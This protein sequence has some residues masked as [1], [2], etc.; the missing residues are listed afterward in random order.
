[1]WSA[2]LPDVYAG[3]KCRYRVA[4]LLNGIG[5]DLSANEEKIVPEAIGLGY[6]KDVD[7]N[8]DLSANDALS[9]FA[10][11]SVDYVFDAH[12]LGN[13]KATKGVL[14]E[15]WRVVKPGGYLVLYEQDKDYYPHVGTPGAGEFR[16]KD[17]FL[18]DV[19]EIL[20]DQGAEVVSQSRHNDSNEYS[21]QLVLRK[22]HGFVRPKE[23]IQEKRKY[24]EMCFPRKK[25]TD[26]E[27]LVVRYGAL[28]DTCWITPVFSEL[29]KEGYHVVFSCTD[30]NA[31]VVRENPNIDEFHIIHKASDIPYAELNSM[32]EEIGC[33]FEKVINLTQT[34]EGELVKCEGS[35]EYNWPHEKRHKICNVNYQDRTMA[36]AGYPDNKG[37]LP[38]L[39]FTSYEEEAG[40]VWAEERKDKFVILWGLAGSAFHKVYPWAEY[41][42]SELCVNYKDIEIVTVGDD[43][44]RILEWNQPRT[45]NKCGL[46][47]VRQ[48]F[49]LTKYADLVIGPDTGLLNA[50]SA[51]STPKIV[52]MSAGSKE[53]LTK[54][55]ENTDTLFAEDCEC[56]PCHKLVYSNSCPKGTIQGIAPKC[57]ENLKPEDVMKAIIKRYSEWK[58]SQVERRNKRRVAAFTIYDDDLTLRLAKRVK[59]S[60]EKFHNGVPFYMYDARDEES[61]LGEVRESACACKAFEIRPRLHSKLLEDFDLVIYLDADTVVCDTLT[62]FFE[63]DYDVAGSL[64]IGNEGYLNAGVNALANKAF[65]DEWTDM[66]Y[67]GDSGPSNQVYFNHLARSGRYKLK[68]VDEEDVFYNEQSRK[69]WK[70]LKVTKHGLRCGGRAVRV[71]HWAGGVPRMEAKLSSS[72]F[73]EDVRKL[74]DR[75][76]DTKDFTEN[77]GEEVSAWT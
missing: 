51:F 68:I 6:T 17:L 10:D 58:D 37:C 74:L 3:R 11:C 70:E 50:A 26:K 35:E 71:L 73:S 27:A 34:I 72:D 42:A 21:W 12:Q 56:Y 66:M 67:K 39:H 44:S 59:A 22:T 5:L 29:K 7:I 65:A 49:L 60:F 19:V 30:Y 33:G 48:S 18:E 9:L 69:H 45:I 2:T 41:I 64:N 15:W 47:S 16:K 36:M 57:M 31:Q 61:L 75:F 63:G 53:N 52:M 43:T 40:R 20:K 76:T 38:E 46:L 25:V 77:V 28:G 55:W 8:V 1:M 14:Y 24:G 4:A 13:F 62:E 32:W 23:E 54:Y